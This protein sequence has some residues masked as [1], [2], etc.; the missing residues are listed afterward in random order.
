MK[1]LLIQNP[2][3]RLMLHALCLFR[4]GKLGWHWAGMLRELSALVVVKR[5]NHCP[6]LRDVQTPSL[7]SQPRLNP[8]TPSA[9]VPGCPQRFRFCSKSRATIVPMLYFGDYSFTPRIISL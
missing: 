1:M 6:A 4:G 2:F 3:G 5:T 8:L 7:Y 9:Q